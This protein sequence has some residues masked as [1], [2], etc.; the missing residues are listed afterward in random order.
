[1]KDDIMESDQFPCYGRLIYCQ[2]D[3]N[4]CTETFV[5]YRLDGRVSLVENL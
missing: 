2:K 4:D 3:F 5:M 1:M